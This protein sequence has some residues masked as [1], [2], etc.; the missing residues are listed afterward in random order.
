MKAHGVLDGQDVLVADPAQ[1]NRLHNKGWYGAP[2]TGN[3]LRLSIPEAVHCMQADR[4][5]VE[6]WDVAGLLAHAGAGEQATCLAYIDLRNRGLVV[7]P[8]PEGLVA[9]HRG[10]APSKEPWFTTRAFMER[11]PISMADLAGGSSVVSIVDEDGQLT[12][13]EVAAIAPQG[14]AAAPEFE[15][16]EATVLGD[17]VLVE[18]PPLVAQLA[19]QFIGTAHGD[20]RLLSLVEAASLSDALQLPDDFAIVAQRTQPQFSLVQPVHD[21]LRAAGVVTRSGF[22]FGTH[23]RGYA[24]DPD[25]GHAPWLFHCVDAAQPLAWS[26]ISRGVRLAHGVRKE[27][28]LAWDTEPV[29]FLA[30]RW[31]RP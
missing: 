18:S 22:R 24:G 1:A 31:F 27:F 9:W 19:A 25:A 10:D 29:Q 17:Q 26:N 30:V 13:Y 2:Q 15:P 23:L 20:A 6:G 5:D 3:S 8:G 28:V 21:A 16:G 12:H 7:R 11:T 14:D 4:L